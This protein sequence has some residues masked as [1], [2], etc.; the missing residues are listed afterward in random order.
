MRDKVVDK[1]KH[2]APQKIYKFINEN[3]VNQVLSFYSAAGNC[4]NDR[5]TTTFAK[6]LNV[7]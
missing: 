2:K 7:K 1:A 4:S 5:D 3:P 6:P